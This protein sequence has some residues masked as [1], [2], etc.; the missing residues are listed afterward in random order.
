MCSTKYKFVSEQVKDN[1]TFQI[2][3]VFSD[4]DNNITS[5]NQ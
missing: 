5:E 4:F 2:Y 1:F 3:F